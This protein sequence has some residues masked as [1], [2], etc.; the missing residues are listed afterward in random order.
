MKAKTAFALSIL[1][2][3]SI[4]GFAQQQ[5]PSLKS[6]YIPPSVEEIKNLNSGNPLQIFEDNPDWEL[7]DEALTRLKSALVNNNYIEKLDSMNEYSW[8][9]DSIGLWKAIGS[10]YYLFDAL[11]RNYSFWDTQFDG[12]YGMI[13]PDSK[14]LVDWNTNYQITGVQQLYWNFEYWVPQSQT[15]YGYDMDGRLIHTTNSGY[16]E[17]YSEWVD[18]SS[19]T[20]EYNV[21]GL[22]SKMISYRWDNTYKFWTPETMSEYSYNPDGLPKQMANYYWSGDTAGWWEENGLT[23]YYYDELRRDT[24]LYGYYWMGE[25]WED[26]YR[27]VKKYDSKNR[28]IEDAS[29]YWNGEMRW[30]DGSYKNEYIFDAN[31][32][33]A[34]SIGYE[35]DQFLRNWYIYDKTEKNWDPIGN[36]IEEIY[37]LYDTIIQDY[38]A[39][40]K[41]N[42]FYDTQLK[43]EDVAMPYYW[44]SEFMDFVEMNDAFQNKVVSV[45]EYFWNSDFKQWEA[46]ETDTLYYSKLFDTPVNEENCKADFEWTLGKTLMDV[47]FIN[48]SD[49]AVVAW[50][51]MFG[52]GVSSTKENPTHIYK[53]PGNY[54]VVLTTIDEH[55]FCSNTI[56][57]NVMAGIPL[58][59]AEFTALVDTV[60]QVVSLTNIS[61]GNNLK[62]FWSFGDGSMSKDENPVHTYEFPGSYPIW[63]SVTDDATKCMDMLTINIKVGS[64]PCNAEFVGFIDSSS[65]TVVLRAKKKN[66]QNQYRWTLGDGTVGFGANLNH[67]FS[68]PGNYSASLTVSNALNG[69]VES[70]KESFLVG[71]MS[72]GG[73][74]MYIYG[75]GEKSTVAFTNKSIGSELR[76]HWDFNDSETS[77]EE[78][79]VHKFVLPGYYDV[80]LTVMTKDGQQNTYC[81]KIFAGEESKDHCLANFEY[82]L[83]EEDDLKIYCMDRSSGEPDTWA[84]I[85]NDQVPALTIPNPDWSASGPGFVKIRQTITNSKNGCVDNAFAL[86]NIGAESMLK[87]EFGYV[88]RSDN[89]K[90]DTYPIDFIGVSLGDAGKLKWS[91]GDGTY[92]STSINPVHQYQDPGTYEVCLTITNG[93]NGD[94]ATSCEWITVGQTSREKVFADKVGLKSWPNPFSETAEVEVHLLTNSDID[95]SVY[96]LV[97]RK[98]RTIA[99][100]NRTAGTHNFNLNSSGLEEGNYYLILET[101]YGRARQIISIIR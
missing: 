48:S 22:V 35:W 12:E 10:E 41:T 52:D 82:T 101:G 1:V 70:R 28:V 37:S 71:R 53:K 86:V 27:Q 21:D 87:A 11:G 54:R 7:S 89:N 55:G 2:I 92:D 80:C 16:D 74:A 84:W 83:S 51:W 30:W 23:E 42:W 29:F 18:Y 43:M 59:K 91:F 94:T 100:E 76:Y 20:T 39:N 32:R 4:G 33:L 17:A 65:N 98:V 69:C 25:G 50:Y 26:S 34:E 5:T 19:D 77:T 79:P 88:I 61:S 73:Q 56:V 62:Y 49:Q 45:I 9:Y 31:E 24:A 68:H 8:Y 57:K 38:Y 95:L 90:A 36:I 63:L 78:D 13:I 97:G 46:F 44:T 15:N 3:F 93:S 72:P 75:G 67:T 40:E 99:K 14:T 58:C 64:N 60:K 81:Q 85:Y 6:D 66:P 47:N 96:D